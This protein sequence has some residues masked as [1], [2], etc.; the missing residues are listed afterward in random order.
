MRSQR[1]SSPFHPGPTVPHWVNRLVAG[2]L[3]SPFHALLSRTTMLLTFTRRKS[4]RRYTIPVRY[5]RTNETVLT[6][7]DSPWWRN[8]R[9][10][11]SVDL[12]IAGQNMRGRA[13]VNT[14]PDDVE[15]GIRAMLRQAPSDAH[16]YQVRLD[17]HSQPDRASLKQAA[18]LHV[19]ITI[20]TEHPA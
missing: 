16:F 7:T 14:D 4:G 15:Q 8:L 10:G 12:S 11:V 17:R 9:G 3:R 13:E 2:L 19:L 18:Q 20:Q 1:L 6:L 5:L